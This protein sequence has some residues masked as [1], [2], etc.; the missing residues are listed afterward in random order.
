MR[1]AKRYVPTAGALPP[2]PIEV[3][4]NP[5]QCSEE[6]ADRSNF[7][8]AHRAELEA[9]ALRRKKTGA[10]REVRLFALLAFALALVVFA[11]AGC[12][13]RVNVHWVEDED[14]LRAAC[15]QDFLPEPSG[16]A[17][18]GVMS[19]PPGSCDIYVL[20]PGGPPSFDEA[21]TVETLGH[22][23]LHCLTGRVHR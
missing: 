18:G 20:S 22:E 13:S 8:E 23:F 14:A 19:V 7:C 6:A 11:L 1:C 15:G 4:R 9:L 5:P 16:C 2:P 12:S 10:W 3:L 21:R 17:R